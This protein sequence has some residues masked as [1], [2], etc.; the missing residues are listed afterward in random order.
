[1]MDYFSPEELKNIFENKVRLSL[2]RGID[3]LSAKRFFELHPDYAENISK[4]YTMEHT[5]FLRI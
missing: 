1:M 3:G 2:T 4:K 5:N